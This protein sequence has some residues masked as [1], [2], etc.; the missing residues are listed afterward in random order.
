MFTPGIRQIS[1][2][3]NTS[4][5][6]VIACQ[7]GYVVMLGIGP[8]VLAPLSETFGRK[9]LYHVCFT[10]FTLLQ[11]PAALSLNVA[12]LITVRTVTGFFGSMWYTQNLLVNYTKKQ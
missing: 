4:E 7:T 9:H 11:V 10:F 1:E 12:M 2:S 8:L 6:A 3:L 5:E